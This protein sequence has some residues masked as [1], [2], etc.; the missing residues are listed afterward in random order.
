MEVAAYHCA[1]E[2]MSAEARFMRMW[3]YHFL[4]PR[5]RVGSKAEDRRGKEEI[6]VAK[7]MQFV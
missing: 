3:M 4:F 6:S 5:A 1:G 2:T 7:A